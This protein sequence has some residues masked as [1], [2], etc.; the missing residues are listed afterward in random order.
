MGIT[1]PEVTLINGSGFNSSNR[2][3]DYSAMSIDPVDDSTFWFTGMYTDGTGNWATRIG[4]FSIQDIVNPPM[5]TGAPPPVEADP[6]RGDWGGFIFNATSNARIDP[7]L[8][9]FGGG[10][11]PL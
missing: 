2:W 9:T 10:L 4:S 3:G 1:L 6:S 8:L 5:V 7:A 11:L